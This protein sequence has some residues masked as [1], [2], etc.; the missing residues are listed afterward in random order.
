MN[1]LILIVSGL[2]GVIGLFLVSLKIKSQSQ[3]KEKAIETET[4]KKRRI[5]IL[6]FCLII[7]SFILL[8]YSQEN[9]NSSFSSNLEGLTPTESGLNLSTG[10]PESLPTRRIERPSNFELEVLFT[11]QAPF[12][13]W[14]DLHNE[15]CEEA[16]LIMAKYWLSGQKLSRKKA[17][18]E[19]LVSIYWQKENW[20]GHYDL[21]VEKTVE[22]AKEY[23]GFEK[24]Y[25]KNK[26]TLEDIKDELSKG[27]LVIVPTAGRLLENQYYRHPGPVYHM[28]VVR[29]YDDKEQEIITNDP[30]T[31][32]GQGFKYTYQN[33]FNSIHDWP[34]PFGQKI[35]KEQAAKEILSGEKAMIVVER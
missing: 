28:L 18:Q 34:L 24:I 3:D 10:E 26:I 30:G 31:K 2:I 20:G 29:G 23:F 8:S 22:L 35:T 6:S 21:S 5:L 9:E 19:I 17:D 25:V 15:A 7:A 27:N 11:S 33:F 32:R 16:V 13:I 4:K 1:Y 14:D 12:Q